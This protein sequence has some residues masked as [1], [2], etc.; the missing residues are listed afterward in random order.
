MFPLHSDKAKISKKIRRMEKT[1]A[2]LADLCSWFLPEPDLAMGGLR[3]P[4]D[5]CL[6]V[7]VL[8]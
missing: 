7:E 3:F 2:T 6:S 1:L 4:V 8:C 5:A